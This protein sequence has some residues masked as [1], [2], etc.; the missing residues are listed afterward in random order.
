[1]WLFQQAA[2]KHE[3]I[4]LSDKIE[5]KQRL[6]TNAEELLKQLEAEK[7]SLEM[8]MAELEEQKEGMM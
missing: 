3:I 2:L 8:K 4:D 7:V 6:V 5:D 1:L